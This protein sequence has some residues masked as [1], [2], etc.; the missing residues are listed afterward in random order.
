MVNHDAWLAPERRLQPAASNEGPSALV[1]I[2]AEKEI[3]MFL[4]AKA[5]AP[6]LLLDLINQ[7][8]GLFSW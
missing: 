6:G 2:R 1:R 4:Q 5:R 8:I 7:L 3:P